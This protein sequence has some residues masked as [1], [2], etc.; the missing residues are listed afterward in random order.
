MPYGYFILF[1]KS[2]IASTCTRHTCYYNNN[3]SPY[4]LICEGEF[5][6]ENY[7]KLS[8]FFIC[9]ALQVIITFRNRNFVLFCVHFIFI[10]FRIS[11]QIELN[12]KSINFIPL[13]WINLNFAIFFLKK[14]IYLY[15]FKIFHK[16]LF[17][18]FSNWNA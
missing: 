18:L 6:H 5:I 7:L 4:L 3:T 2:K 10:K 9:N 11:Y 1:F 17:N 16:N 14:L 15:I 13:V 12:W 8:V